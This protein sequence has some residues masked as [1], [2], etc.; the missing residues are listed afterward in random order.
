MI[1]IIE[2]NELFNTLQNLL[3]IHTKF[4]INS[5]YF[6]LK[7]RNDLEYKVGKYIIEIEIKS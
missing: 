7:N 3:I 1:Y 4:K 5:I 2:T 6:K